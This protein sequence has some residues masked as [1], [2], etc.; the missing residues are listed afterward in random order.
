[1]LFCH[2]TSRV[3]DDKYQNLLSEKGGMGFPYLAYMDA[4]GNVIAKPGG[5]SVQAFE[6]TLS[7]A[8]VEFQQ[9][10]DAAADG[11]EEAQRNLFV[12]QV[13]FQH[14][15]SVDDARKAMAKVKGLSDEQSKR[16]ESMLTDQE[17]GAILSSVR[18]LNEAAAAGKKALPMLKAGRIPGGNNSLYFWLFIGKHA[19]AEKDAELL[20]RAISELEGNRRAARLVS[21]MKAALEKMDG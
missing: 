12:K 19:E 9:L 6:A 16:I 1:M 15:A 10:K 3:E 8:V 18:S 2:I 21:D 14:F 13:E 4:D 7:G 11:D 17:F 20:K 5:R